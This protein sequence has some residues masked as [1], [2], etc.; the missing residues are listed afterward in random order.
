MR[1]R[2]AVAVDTVAPK[3]QVKDLTA[4]FTQIPEPENFLL[5]SEDSYTHIVE[6]QIVSC[7]GSSVPDF[8]VFAVNEWGSRI[9][10]VLG[11]T[12]DLWHRR[13][14]VFLSIELWPLHALLCHKITSWVVWL[15]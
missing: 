1:K 15:L 10:S 11:L 5:A 2:W 4:F 8:A 6:R 14:L 12:A 7:V 9:V 3:G 13:N